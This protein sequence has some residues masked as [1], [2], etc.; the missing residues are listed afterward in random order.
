MKKFLGRILLLCIPIVL[1]LHIFNALY[2]RTNY[3][4]NLNQLQKF[5]NVPDSISI[6]NFGSSHGRFSFD[7]HDTGISTAFNFGLEGQTLEYDYALLQH[8]KHRFSLDAVCIIPVSYFSFFGDSAERMIAFKPRYYR[9][10]PTSLIPDGRLM[11]SIQFSKFPVLSAGTNLLSVISDRMPQTSRLYTNEAVAID[12]RRLG[13]DRFKIW[14]KEFTDHGDQTIGSK[15]AVL[16]E[17]IRFC[18]AHGITP[19]LVTTPITEELYTLIPNQWKTRFYSTM[20]E[21]LASTDYPLYLDYSQDSRFTGSLTLFSD[22]DHL[23]PLGRSVF[24]ETVIGDLRDQ[25]KLP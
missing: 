12:K 13:A 10:L 25:G 19:V 14:K 21:V 6:A 4:K 22:G 1:L 11:E 7:Y 9:I 15:K 17:M 16:S 3:W 20:D 18:Q 2:I 23:N 8:H 5:F 24:T